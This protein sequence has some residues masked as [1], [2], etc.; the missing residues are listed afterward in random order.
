MRPA[1]LAADD[2]GSV[3]TWQHAW[4]ASEEHFGKR[5]E[6]SVLLEPSSPLRHPE[7]VERTV[8]TMVEGG[9]AAAATVTPTPAHYTPHKSLLVDEAGVVGFF[10]PDGGRFATRQRVPRLFH[11]NGICYAVERQTLLEEGHIIE[12]DCAAVII[13][14]PVVNID[15]PFDLELA[16]WL[17]ERE[18]RG[19]P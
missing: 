16:E 1:D 18:R 9:H 6:V 8:A 10:I 2:A 15:E 17:L 7:D 11:R 5:F 13:D 19:S 14:R 4:R 3:E 12:R